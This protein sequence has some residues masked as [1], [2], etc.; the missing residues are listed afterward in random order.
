[1]FKF[2]SFK[3]WSVLAGSLFALTSVGCGKATDPGTNIGYIPGAVLPGI[4][5]PSG[6][7][8]IGGAC[9]GT[10]EQ[11]CWNAM[12]MVVNGICKVD[13]YFG[14]DLSMVSN[15]P[16]L[17]AS[18]V[19]GS[20]AWNTG[21]GLYAGDRIEI[22]ANGGWGSQSSGSFLGINWNFYSSSKCSKVSV[23][24]ISDGSLI[25]NNGTAA[26]LLASDGSEI[27]AVGNS[28][29]KTMT[30]QGVLKLGFNVPADNSLCSAA[31]VTIR[32]MRCQ[33][34]A[35]QSVSCP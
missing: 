23:A 33:N 31:G 3:S 6:Q 2:K 11:A 15:V 21:I 19:T 4:T 1:M 22:Y 5:C 12:G 28:V 10:F 14:Q 8:G 35:G 24:G 26:G 18:D 20:A 27:F 9:G 34:S 30:R 29:S 13:R 17:T 7:I 32:V 25:L 16:R